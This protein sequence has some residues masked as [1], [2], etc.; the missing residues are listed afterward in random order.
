MPAIARQAGLHGDKVVS[1]HELTGLDDGAFG[2]AVGE[3]DLFARITPDTKSRI[4]S[5]LTAKG[6]YVA[7]VGDGVND[8]PAIKQSR[9]GVA[10][11]DGAQITKDVA[12]LVLLENTMSTL[13]AALDEGR[14][15]TQKIL[16]SAKLYLAKNWVTIFA[17]LFAGFVGLPFP[18][19]PRLVSWVA[20]ITVGVPCALLAFGL[21]RP[22]LTR[23]FIDDVLGYTLLVGLIGSVV[24]VLVYI[25]S[26]P[27]TG[28]VQQARTAFALANLH[29]AMHVFWDAHD[30]S[31]FS[32]SSWR[33]HP[34]EALAGLVLLGVGFFGPLVE[35]HL[36]NSA[37]P[38]PL[39]WALIVALPL[40]G[41][42]ALDRII[43][44]D[45][46]RTVVHTLQA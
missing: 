33:A 17:I 18:G 29:Y 3:A 25:L 27:L 16:A 22:A 46:A 34:R 37:V 31:V 13:P 2:K 38:G 23:D 14:R 19:E 15:I 20:S 6:E 24:V 39:Q 28:N 26:F 32:P 11:N 5:A 1:E 45:L 41:S 10:M 7:M 12:A 9:L 36:F 40:A 42:L 30:V 4:V 35:T 21:L 43:H 44:G 8:V